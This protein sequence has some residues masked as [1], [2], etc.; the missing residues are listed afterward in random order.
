[1]AFK[2]KYVSRKPKRTFRK[3]SSRRNKMGSKSFAKKVKNIIVRTAETKTISANTNFTISP[4]NG[5]TPWLDINIGLNTTNMVPSQG[6]GQGDRIGN[7]IRTKRAILTGYLHPYGWNLTNNPVPKPM[8]VKMVILSNKSSPQ[9][10]PN[11]A[12]YFQRGDTSSGPAG[13][14]SDI[15]SVPNRDVNV[16][17]RE[18]TYKLGHASE[19]GNGFDDTQ[20]RQANNDFKMNCKFRVDITK[21]LP[22]T[23]TFND[24]AV[25]FQE[26]N[27]FMRFIMA[28]A[29]GSTS[30]ALGAATVW[31]QVDYKYT[32]F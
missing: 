13:T 30:A 18:K 17:Y 16:I 31:Y 27:V 7:K 1:M 2:R 8:E 14:L 12:N 11:V 32:D 29:D 20:A 3:K 25:G 28:N 10:Y 24:T 4:Y 22:K 21:Y 9:A 6:T 5:S 26:R 23:Y 19:T 15:V